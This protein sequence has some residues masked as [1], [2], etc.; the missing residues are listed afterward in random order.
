M[1][2]EFLYECKD[3]KKQYRETRE[4]Q[5]PQWFTNCDKCNGEYQ[6]VSKETLS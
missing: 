1:T 6:E 2:I 3:C 4:E 5:H